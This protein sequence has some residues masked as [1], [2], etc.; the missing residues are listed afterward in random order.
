[1]WRW[2]E[3]AKNH[4][5]KSE[6]PQANP[7]VRG[8]FAEGHSADK[9]QYLEPEKITLLPAQELI[10]PGLAFSTMSCNMPIYRFGNPTDSPDSRA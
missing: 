10:I 5:A 6:M 9:R 3:N 4:T 2:A 7:L 1:V 8:L